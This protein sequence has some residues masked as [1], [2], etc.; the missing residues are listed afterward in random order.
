[1][2]E[3]DKTIVTITKDE[4]DKLNLEIAALR[5]SRWK[6]TLYLAALLPTIL[7]SATIIYVFTSG[8]FQEV[9]SRNQTAQLRSESEEISKQKVILEQKKEEILEKL[10]KTKTLIEQSKNSSAEVDAH[11]EVI[12]NTCLSCPTPAW[13]ESYKTTIAT[14]DEIEKILDEQNSGVAAK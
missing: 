4:L 5:K 12:A 6:K 14:L 10:K 9:V 7:V 1:M 11:I 2:I 3:E 8:Y 13:I